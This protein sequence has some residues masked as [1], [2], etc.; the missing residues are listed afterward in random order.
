MVHHVI[1][2]VKECSE[3]ESFEGLCRV[4]YHEKL[5][6]I[7]LSM[8]RY[9]STKGECLLDGCS[10]PKRSKGLCERHYGASI[11]SGECALC[12]GIKSSKEVSVCS[13]CNQRL[14]QKSLPTEKQCNG[15]LETLPME[16]FGL[17]RSSGG[18]SKWRSRCRKCE[19][20]K[21][22]VYREMAKL[23][24]IER[25]DRSSE[26]KMRP[27][28]SLRKYA[29]SLGISWDEVVEVYPEDNRCEI[30]GNTPEE[31]SPSGRT[32][33]LALD[34]DHKTGELRG[35]LCGRCNTGI[36]QFKDSVELLE[37]A[38]LYLNK[39]RADVIETYYPSE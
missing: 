18:R 12:G 1:C 14:I 24:N 22:K 15:C 26:K 21:A 30:C 29:K 25:G 9:T 4:H 3:L 20:A 34:H 16:S 32:K 38:I 36:G 35:F 13:S 8:G 7:R 19:A 27:F 17:R 37:G 10:K 33:R 5:S 23:A 2:R 11:S 28:H 31:S 39:K 6:E